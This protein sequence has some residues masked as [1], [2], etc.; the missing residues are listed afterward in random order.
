MYEYAGREG[1]TPVVAGSA[2]LKG[3]LFDTPLSEPICFQWETSILYKYVWCGRV[4]TLSTTD[5]LVSAADSLTALS[6]NGSREMLWR[7]PCC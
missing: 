7:T 2:C 3:K 1:R 5:M 6:A 4:T